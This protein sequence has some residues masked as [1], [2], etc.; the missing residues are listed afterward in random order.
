MTELGLFVC[1][2]NV[3]LIFLTVF[4]MPEL[5]TSHGVMPLCTMQ[6]PLIFSTGS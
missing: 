2:P 6:K 3:N 5:D 1:L 4:C